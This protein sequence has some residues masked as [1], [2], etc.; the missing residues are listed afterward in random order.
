M[1]LSLNKRYSYLNINFHIKHMRRPRTGEYRITTIGGEKVK[2]YVPDPLPPLPSIEWGKVLRQAHDRA[3]TALARLDGVATTL[4]D[5]ELFIYSYVRKEAL[6]SSQIEGTQSTLTDLFAF[7]ANAEN[8]HDFDDVKEVSNYVAAQD[9][10]ISRLKKKLPLCNRL[11]REAHK[12]LLSRG[13][14]SAQA[15]GEFRKSQNW[16]GGTRPGNAHFVPPPHEEIETLLSQ[17]EKFINDKQEEQP[18]LARAALA[19]LQ[20]ET[21]HPFL[22]GNGRTGRLLITL[23]LMD[24]E[25]IHAPLLYLSLYLK[26]HRALYYDLLTRV[27]ETGD[28]EEWLIFFFEGVEQTAKNATATAHSLIKIFERDNHILQEHGRLSPTLLQVHHTIQ[29]LPVF[30]AAQLAK[31]TKLTIPTINRVLQKMI[32][33]KIVKEVT[34]RKRNRLFAYSQLLRELD[35]GTEPLK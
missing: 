33:L 12:I 16:I 31:R 35:K 29:Q 15:P 24:S 20:F 2:A 7:E 19:H 8:T 3:L 26:Q 13:R 11:L 17:L 34:G 10:A 23:M 6:L 9:H 18:I 5:V 32:D 30:T 4:P 1:A 14:G 25:I 22:D 27:R 28:W 21:I